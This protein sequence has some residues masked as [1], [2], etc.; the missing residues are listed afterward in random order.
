MESSDFHHALALLDWQ[1]ELGATEAIGETPVNRYDLPDKIQ[2]KQKAAQTTV[3]PAAARA[4]EK[5]D[6]V[7]AARKAAFAAQDLDQLRAALAGFEHCDLK[8]GARNLVFS[9]GVAGAR[10]MVIGE[11]P[12]RE[13]DLQGRPF[14]GRA[15]QLLDRMLAAIDMGRD[16]QSDP[17][18]I[19]NVVPWRPPQNRDPSSD[20]IAM[21]RPFV[22]RHI[23]LA[24]PEVL[25]IMGNVSAQALLGKRG[26]TRLRGQWVEAFGVPALPM[27]HPAYLL[28]NTAAKR[29]AWADLLSLQARLHNG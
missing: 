18:Y 28:R 11:A 2:P 24:K 26:I 17:V 5:T 27:F 25:V 4:A 10:V 8:R 14:V 1:I 22:E 23:A 7:D 20:E 21:M 13:E 15:G 19:T 29:E 16:R 12:G 6:P 9:D 3:A